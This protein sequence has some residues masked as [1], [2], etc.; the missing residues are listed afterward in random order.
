LSVFEYLYCDPGANSSG[1][2]ATYAISCSGIFGAL[3]S[4][5][6]ALPNCGFVE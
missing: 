1:S 4:E 6:S 3:G 5:P 2:P